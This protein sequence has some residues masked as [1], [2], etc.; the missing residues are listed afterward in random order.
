MNLPLQPGAARP[1]GRA[2]GARPAVAVPGGRDR[3]AGLGHQPRLL[4]RQRDRRPTAAQLL[5]GDL[6]LS[7][8]QREASAEER[9]AIDALG[10]SS[11]SV[12]TR[13]MLVA[14]RRPQPA[15]RAV[16]RRCRNW[17]LAG[18]VDWAPGGKRPAGAE[19][20]IGREIAERLDLGLGDSVR[21]GRASYRVSAIIDKM[22]ARVRLRARA[23]GADGRSRAG[24]ERADPAGQHQQH[25]LPHPPARRRRCR[26][27]PARPSSGASPKAAGARPAAT[28]RARARGASSTGWAR[29]C[30]WSRCRRWRSAGSA[31]R[32][33]PPP[34]P[35]RAARPSPS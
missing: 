9:A 24:D 19:V 21:I 4:D 26:R 34:L 11:K 2:V 6:M 30:C 22:P 3:R 28:R 27:P 23:A 10:R 35:P 13:A 5:G 31:C 12:T 33:R 16:R 32:A 29:C 15:R 17:P 25:Q 1:E 8:A 20:A 18:K 14:P 7:V